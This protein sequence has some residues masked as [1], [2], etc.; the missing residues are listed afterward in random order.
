[1][2]RQGRLIPER[3]PK[4]GNFYTALRALD[5]ADSGNVYT[6]LRALDNADE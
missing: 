3:S 1:M 6:A 4:F 5:T 2:S